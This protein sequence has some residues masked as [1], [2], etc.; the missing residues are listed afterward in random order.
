MCVSVFMVSLA[1][2]V[3]LLFLPQ[4]VSMVKPLREPI[5]VYVNQDGVVV[6]ATIQ[7][8]K[9]THHLQHL[10]RLIAD[11]GYVFNLGS[12]NVNRDGR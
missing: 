11:T 5:C 10:Q 4:T 8:V 2:N 1:H 3:K 7:Y 6:Y 12:A 9:D